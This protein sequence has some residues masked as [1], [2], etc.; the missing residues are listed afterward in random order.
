MVGAFAGSATGISVTVAAVDA[1]ATTFR[2]VAG[3]V[4]AFKAQLA[5]GNIPTGVGKRTGIISG[6]V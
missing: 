4:S 2:G 6:F 1:T 3:R 5:G